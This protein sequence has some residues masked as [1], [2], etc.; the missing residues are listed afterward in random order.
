M[1]MPGT[2]EQK[3][4]TYFCTQCHSLERVV[5]SSHTADDFLKNV[6]PRMTSYSTQS[7]VHAPKLVPRPGRGDLKGSL[8]A[9]PTE[10]A[11]YLASVNR[12]RT[13]RLEYPLKALPRPAGKAT[14]VILTEY[15]LPRNITQA[16][17]VVVDSDGIVWFNQFGEPNLGRLD[18]RTGEIREYPIPILHKDESGGTLDLEIDDD[19]LLWLGLNNQ[20]G[21]ASFDRAT[22]RMEVFRL[23]EELAK[24]TSQQMVAPHSRK[25]DGKVWFNGGRTRVGRMELATR[26]MDPWIDPFKGLPKDEP[27]SVYSLHTDAQNNLFFLDFGNAHIGRVNAKTLAVKLFPTPTKLSRPRRGHLD[28]K[29]GLW[30]AEWRGGN[31]G[32]FDIA[33]ET[34][35]EWPTSIPH[36]SPYN[37]VSDGNGRVWAGGLTSDRLVMIDT[38]TRESV[39]YLLPRAMNIRRLFLDPRTGAV[40]VGDNSAT[41]GAKVLRLEVLQ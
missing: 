26:K 28:G 31:V 21:F 5:Q 2:D 24:G 41:D 12:S 34:M 13:G 6:F 19:G 25:A 36:F 4:D 20:T 35:Q 14:R 8:G 18:P 29:G 7:P 33:K 22:E 1:S 3:K 38:R 16:H 39:A 11:Q 15:E 23:P 30:F 40:W 10:V 32:R 27:H 17:D 9:E 37:V